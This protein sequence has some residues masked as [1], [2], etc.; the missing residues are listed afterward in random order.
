MRMAS[1]YDTWQVVAPFVLMLAAI[2]YSIANPAQADPYAIG[3]TED[4]FIQQSALPLLQEAYSRAG[5]EV[6]FIGLP[7]RRSLYESN[8]GNIDA[9]AV[10]IA[11]VNEQFHNL[12]RVP[13]PLFS[14]QGRVYTRTPGEAPNGWDDLLNHK[15]AIRKGII[16]EEN[17]V[18]N[19]DKNVLRATSLE[20]VFELLLSERV[21]FALGN[22]IAAQIL[23]ETRY[24]D[25]GI[26]ATGPPLAEYPLHHFVN[27]KNHTL[28]TTL[29]HILQQMALSGELKQLHQESVAALARSLTKQH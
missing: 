3:Y 12:V 20:Q 15:V 19:K 22:D 8:K 16:W 28:V 17:G 7:A 6:K 23:I 27:K 21:R 13:T 9:E 5:I 2:T 11:T 25:S 18:K 10:R 26:Y 1:R 4:N 14:F 24:P 29:D